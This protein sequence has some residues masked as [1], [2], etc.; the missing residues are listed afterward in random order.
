[1]MCSLGSSFGYSLGLALGFALATPTTS[2]AQAA[3]T[4][5]VQRVEGA[6][7]VATSG[8]TQRPVTAGMALGQGATLRTPA[9][10]RV[11]LLCPD[12]LKVV[13]GPASVVTVDGWL[14]GEGRTFGVGVLDGIAGFLF[15][16]S[17]AV[18]VRAPSAVAA[19]RSTDWAVRANEGVTEVFARS[20]TVSVSA[21]GGTARLGPGDGIDVSK[22]GELNPVVK[23]RPPRIARFAELLGPDW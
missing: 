11:T 14:P 1:M 5:S 18:R 21:D 15:K 8:L 10:S 19:V 22:R 13:V 23:W 20:G 16:G 12:N 9:A 4:C 3:D 17:T 7:T 2:H 6:A